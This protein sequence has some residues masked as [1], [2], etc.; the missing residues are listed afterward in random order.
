MESELSSRE[1]LLLSINHEEPDRVPICFRAFGQLSPLEVMEGTG[2]HPGW[3]NPW[4]RAIGLARLG[5]DEPA[6]LHL[7]SRHHPDVSTRQWWER[8]P[9]EERPLM[10]KEWE[11][12][13]GPLRLVVQETEDYVELDLP[14][15]GDN[16][17]SRGIEFPL[18]GPEDLEK[19]AFLFYEPRKEDLDDFYRYVKTVKSFAATH[20]LLVEGCG[21]FGMSRAIGLL[22]PTEFLI[23]VMDNR[24]FVVAL[25]EMIHHWDM[26]RLEILLDVG[27]D[28]VYNTGCYEVTELFSPSVIRELFLPFRREMIKVIHQAGAKF[29]YY[30]ITGIMPLLADYKEIG[31]DILSSLDPIGSGGPLKIKAVDLA[32]AKEEIGDEVCLW[33]GVDPEHTIERG[34][35]EEVRE[36]VREAIFTC[37]PGGGFVL[38]PSGNINPPNP[39]GKAYDNVLT[40]IEAG[41]EFGRYPIS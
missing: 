14:L 11:T 8:Q 3:R 33:G 12:P 21:L 22:K 18:K 20:G 2:G 17:W 31:I 6:R 5:V 15:Y 25:L 30:T 36:A 9:G 27:V 40:F 24:E 41:H 10:I 16:H 35:R 34:T 19:L 26:K 38:S 37:A 1:R 32:K 39:C 23:A 7:P 29:H 28:V 4:E 13:K